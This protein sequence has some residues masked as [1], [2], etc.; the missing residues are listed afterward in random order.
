MALQAQKPVSV[1]KA[2]S[3]NTT[4]SSSKKKSSTAKPSKPK[5]SPTSKTPVHKGN[6][7]GHDFVDLGLPSG[8][9]WA[10]VNIGAAHPSDAGYYFAWGEISPKDDYSVQT[11]RTATMKLGDISGNPK[12]DAAAAI[13]GGSWRMPTA[14]EL[15]EL[16]DNCTFSW[17]TI[18]GMNCMQVFGPNGQS[19]LLPCSGL[20]VGKDLQMKGNYAGFYTSTPAER[21]NKETMGSG[22]YFKE[23]FGFSGCHPWDRESGRP[24]R[25]VSY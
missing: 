18:S 10:T 11:S 22:F 21:S 12:Y 1:P 25:P 15:S 8:I 4:S 7:M 13:W 17:V 9:K 6:Y 24:I 3:T 14:K 23:G 5:A 16:N 20:K 2:P 19:I